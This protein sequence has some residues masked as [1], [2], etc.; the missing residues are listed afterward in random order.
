MAALLVGGVAR[1]RL[2]R[3]F[4]DTDDADQRLS[5]NQV[6]TMIWQYTGL[7]MPEMQQPY[8]QYSI[9]DTSE[10]PHLDKAADSQLT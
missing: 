2:S 5:A 9:N 10:W 3:H 8:S 7:T 1:D 4:R 6:L